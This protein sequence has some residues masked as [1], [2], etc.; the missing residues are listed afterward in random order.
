MSP[1]TPGPVPAAV[2]VD[3]AAALL[4]GV[5]HLLEPLGG[6]VAWTGETLVSAIAGVVVGLAVAGVILLIGRLRTGG[7]REPAPR[8]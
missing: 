5:L 2:G 7:R 1:S 3:P 4:H 8:H 6:V